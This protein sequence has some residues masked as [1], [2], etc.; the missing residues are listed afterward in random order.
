MHQIHFMRT[1]RTVAISDSDGRRR[2][3]FRQMSIVADT[4]WENDMLWSTGQR[5][6][7]RGVL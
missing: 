1:G 6:T 5:T 2:A 3:C 4:G 7:A